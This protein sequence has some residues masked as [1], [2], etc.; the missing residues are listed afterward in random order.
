MRDFPKGEHKWQ[1]SANG[2]ASPRWRQEREILYLEGPKLMAVSVAM[3]PAFS[4]GAPAALFDKRP[5]QF[6]QYDVSSDGKRFVVLERPTGEP[7]L[8]SHVVHNWFEEFR[9]QQREQ[10][11]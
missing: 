6:S 10:G 7:P 11:K 2:G 8:A 3:R 1:I 9:A 5:V 4:P